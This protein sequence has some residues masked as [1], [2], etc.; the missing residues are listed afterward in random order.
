[1]ILQNLMAADLYSEKCTVRLKE[2]FYRN[3]YSAFDQLFLE[4][5]ILL[6]KELFKQW[7]IVTSPIK[8]KTAPF[9]QWMSVHLKKLNA[10]NR[11]SKK[12]LFLISSHCQMI[13]APN[14]P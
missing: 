3:N 12:Y 5:N 10:L 8:I 9:K 14:N 1:M 2:V 13:S 6:L 7:I 4:I 11:S